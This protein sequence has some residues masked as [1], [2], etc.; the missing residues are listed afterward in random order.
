[1]TRATSVPAAAARTFASLA[2]HAVLPLSFLGA[3]LLTSALQRLGVPNLF[4]TPILVG[5]FAGLVAILERARP[6]RADYKPLELPF[7]HEA[8]HFIFNFEFGYGLSLLATALFERWIR[9]V[10]PAST[11]PVHWPL[12]LQLFLAV[13][14][15]EGTSYWQHRLLHRVPSLWRFHALHHSGTRLNF[16]RCV[17]FHF[18]DIATAAFVSY[19]PLAILGAPDD[20]VTL[21]AILLSVMGILQHANIRMRSPNW[22]DRL[23]CTPAV[24]RHHHSSALHEG[25]RNFGNSV[26][27]LDM[28]F[29]T[30][31]APNSAGPATVGIENDPVPRDFLG[32]T[33]G[34]FRMRKNY[35]SA[36]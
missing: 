23:I 31:G 28:L 36:T 2:D 26:M 22:L 12:A 10:I 6:D 5:P 4:V 9:M 18:V 14:C 35:R 1:M 7:L 13:L 17:R 20:I 19:V 8:A 15:Y 30:Y 32:Q 16:L 24:H 27:L 33:L 21:L 29:G 3:Y 25:D 11:W 34:P